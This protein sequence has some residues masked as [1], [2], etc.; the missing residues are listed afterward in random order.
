MKVSLNVRRETID[1]QLEPEDGLAPRVVQAA[2]RSAGI[3]F[4]TVSSKGQWELR[5]IQIQQLA[6][7]LDQFSPSWDGRAL[8]RLTRLQQDNKLREI[9]DGRAPRLSHRLKFAASLGLTP[10]DEQWEAAELMS[11]PEVRRFALLWKPGF[12]EN[13]C[14]DLC[15]P[16]TVVERGC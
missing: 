9:A 7:A 16:R 6:G 1:V 15:G 12:W 3:Q 13:W 4:S 8:E 10:Y 14:N 2:L 11:A 5:S